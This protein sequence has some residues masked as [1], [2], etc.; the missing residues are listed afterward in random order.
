MTQLLAPTVIGPVSECSTTVELQGQLTGAR[1]VIY[2][3]AQAVAH[4]VA[5][6]SRQSFPLDA[7]ATLPA[8]ERIT[9]TQDDG[10]G[11]S[12]H[13]VDPLVWVQRSPATVGAV[14]FTGPLYQC[15]G[16]V[17]VT[18]AVPGAVLTARVGN[19]PVRGTGNAEHGDAR[20]GFS[21]ALGAGEQLTVSQTACGVP[22]GS[23]TAPPAEALPRVLP[24]PRLRRPLWSCSRTVT[25]EGVLPG[26]TVTL[27]RPTL[28]LT[29]S[30]VFD[31]TSLYF[32]L[33]K[34]LVK[35][36]EISVTQAFSDCR[37]K[38][39]SDTDKVVDAPAVPPP[40]IVGKPCTNTRAADLTGLIPGA[41]VQITVN[42]ALAGTVEAADDAMLV[43]LPSLR[44]FDTIVARQ[45]LCG[46]WSGPSNS[47]E[48]E[49][50]SGGMYPS[51]FIV[52]P[53]Y[54]CGSA[55]RVRDLTP[56]Y[57]WISIVSK[58]TGDVLAMVRATAPEMTVRISPVLTEGDTLI[59]HASGCNTLSNTETRA[60][61]HAR[62]VTR[63]VINRGLPGTRLLEVSGIVPGAWIDIYINNAWDRSYPIGSEDEVVVTSRD[64]RVNDVVKIRQ[65]I[66]DMVSGFGP[67]FTVKAP[68]VAKFTPSVTSGVAPLVV[69]FTNQSTGAITSSQWTFAGAALPA[70]PSLTSPTRTFAQPGSITASLTVSGPGG[71]NTAT[72]TIAVTAPAPVGYDELLIQNCHTGH[73]PIH[74]YY[75]RVGDSDLDWVPINDSPHNADYNEWGTCPAGPNVG[76]RFSADDGVDYEVVCT[77]PQ[78]PGCNTGGP[79][80]PACRRSA[81]F[82]IRGKAGGGTKT[83]IV[84]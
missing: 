26:A 50:T 25:V 10:S 56:G 29:A 16:A 55:V 21:P 82:L 42:G 27:D 22:G 45:E 52:E 83:V 73:R 62:D 75:R 44:A 13:S 3:G 35:G 61:Q 67:D 5:T 69:T 40:F 59:A 74:I 28:G 4:G 43:Q 23:T 64:L 32:Q 70:T 48:V 19:G 84:N 20:F 58:R 30:G 11:P 31:A 72:A 8:G 38:S 41:L 47:V 65:R 1:V 68:P 53:L 6:W 17:W 15:G 71:S 2:A 57:N 36:E 78:L 66:C 79:A 54:E 34:P 63:P 37:E 77:D 76:A 39:A 33:D 14:A 7:G 81:V 12:A 51:P 24:A 80:E 9:A 46:V 60:V 18:G 49:G